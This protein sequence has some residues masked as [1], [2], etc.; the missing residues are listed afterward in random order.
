M[1]ARQSFLNSSAQTGVSKAGT[2]Q[3]TWDISLISPLLPLGEFRSHSSSVS[4]RNFACFP[5][6]SKRYSEHTN[7]ARQLYF[8]DLFTINYNEILT[9]G[10]PV[11][12]ICSW[13]N[14]EVS[15]LHWS[16]FE[17]KFQIQIFKKLSSDACLQHNCQYRLICYR[18]NTTE[19]IKGETFGVRAEI[20]FSFLKA[21]PHIFYFL[22]KWISKTKFWHNLKGIFNPLEY[23][24][25]QLF[26]YRSHN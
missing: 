3:C 24:E 14:R 17:R 9:L 26:D 2:E 15:W 12:L 16:P 1:W 4:P 20:L 11:L 6:E 21:S 13:H 18:K 23:W 10:C 25:R 7:S 19:H 5:K 22:I 8:L